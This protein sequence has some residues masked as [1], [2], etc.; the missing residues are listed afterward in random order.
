MKVGPPPHPSAGQR[1]GAE[2]VIGWLGRGLGVGPTAS[3]IRGVA[4]VAGCQ[5]RTCVCVQLY[6]SSTIPVGGLRRL[7][8]ISA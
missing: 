3:G 2:L 5:G 4:A 6:E 7:R 8:L 1:V